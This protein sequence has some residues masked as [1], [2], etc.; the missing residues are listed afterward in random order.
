MRISDWSS[1]VCS[2]DLAGKIAAD[3]CEN[4]TQEGLYLRMRPDVHGTDGFFAA[5]LERTKAVP[6]EKS[7][8]IAQEA[9]QEAPQAANEGEL[10]FY[11]AVLP[12][13]RRG[14]DG[15]GLLLPDRRRPRPCLAPPLVIRSAARR[16]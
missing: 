16:V 9:T 2:S 11:P 15:V 13:A 6:V 5:V 14:A 7:P 4:L 3:R 10:S 8:E 1:D 12:T